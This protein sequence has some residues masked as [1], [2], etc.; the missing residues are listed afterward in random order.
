MDSENKCRKKR[1]GLL[2]FCPEV[3]GW[4]DR[5]N[6][7]NWLKR[8]LVKKMTGRNNKIKTKGLARACAAIKVPHYSR[9]TLE[10]VLVE[11]KIVVEELQKLEPVAEKKHKELLL[12]RLEHHI[13]EG[14]KDD[15]EQV[16]R[17]IQREGN[18]KHRRIK[19]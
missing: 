4:V 15:A 8:Y 16:K 11:L 9:W 12:E 18:K 13:D 17:I 14:N 19:R 2:A 6:V 7:L 5:R 3:K 1:V 10:M